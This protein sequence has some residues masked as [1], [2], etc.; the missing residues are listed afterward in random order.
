MFKI[1]KT[2]WL[3][4]SVA[5]LSV[6]VDQLT[7]RLVAT[8]MELYQSW[9]PVPALENIF[10]ITYTTNTGAAFGLFKDWGIFFIG[11]AIVVIAAILYYQQQLQ[12]GHWLLNVAL[13]LQL[14]GASGNLIDR[15]R[16][17]GQVIDFLHV[18]LWPV[19]NVAD[20][21]IVVGVGLL[22]LIMWQESKLEA[23]ANPAPA[24]EQPDPSPS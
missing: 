21:S 16:M 9:A 20:S 7:K 22:I 3:M 6:I 1:L 23:K 5:A 12:N 18:K 13:G 19:F 15:L 10:T 2:S 8:R 17:G 24:T 14:G 11:V 4:V